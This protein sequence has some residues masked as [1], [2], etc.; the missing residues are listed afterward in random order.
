MREG[1][2]HL[3]LRNPTN[4]EIETPIDV[5]SDN[6][7]SEARVKATPV[8]ATNFPLLPSPTPRGDPTP[9]PTITPSPSPKMIAIKV[10]EAGNKETTQMVKQ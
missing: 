2:L 3:I 1:I 5:I 4:K 6:Y 9:R 10:I 7:L 8:P